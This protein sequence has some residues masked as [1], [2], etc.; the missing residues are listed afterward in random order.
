MTLL[1]LSMA[2]F[3]LLGQDHSNNVKFNFLGHVM[4]MIL[5]IVPLSSV[6]EA[7]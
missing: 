3:C 4:P 2:P 6:G 5:S 1:L 7:N